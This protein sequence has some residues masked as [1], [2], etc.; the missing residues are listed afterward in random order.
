ML[1]KFFGH[2][3]FDSCS[4]FFDWCKVICFV[5]EIVL[6]PGLVVCGACSLYTHWYK[7]LFR[8]YGF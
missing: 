3:G 7:K 5:S 4:L 6:A 2:V 1:L 8:A